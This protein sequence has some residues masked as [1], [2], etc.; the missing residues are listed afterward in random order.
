[1]AVFRVPMSRVQEF[2]ML[3]RAT[4]ESLGLTQQEVADSI[5]I[6]VE[7]Y[8]SIERAYTLPSV[9]T[10]KKACLR[11]GLSYRS[12]VRE[13]TRGAEMPRG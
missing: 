1:M 10:L 2:T 12:L 13:I 11:L 3:L 6:S 9:T 7:S 5:D 8:G 4:R